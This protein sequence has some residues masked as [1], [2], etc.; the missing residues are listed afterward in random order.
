MNKQEKIQTIRATAAGQEF[1]NELLR[2]CTPEELELLKQ[3]IYTLYGAK[4]Q[5]I[6]NLGPGIE[7][8]NNNH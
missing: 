2:V 8:T 4:P 7:P 6:V 5:N 3:A 1:I